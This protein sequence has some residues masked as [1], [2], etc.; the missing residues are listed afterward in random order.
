ME[1]ASL[2]MLHILCLQWAFGRFLNKT[3]DMFL[4]CCFLQRQKWGAGSETFRIILSVSQIWSE[5]LPAK[6]N[7]CAISV[8]LSLRWNKC[9]PFLRPYRRPRLHPPAC[10][11]GRTYLSIRVLRKWNNLFS[12]V[13]FFILYLWT[14]IDCRSFGCNITRAS[15]FW[16]QMC[17]S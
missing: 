1:K 7:N 11:W 3:A 8:S 4:F 13:G 6:P 15:N 16:F 9:D 17:E 12:G 14:N 5:L 10:N 2:S